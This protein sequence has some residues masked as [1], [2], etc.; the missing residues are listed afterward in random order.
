MC[1][2]S[3]EKFKPVRRDIQLTVALTAKTLKKCLRYET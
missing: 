3:W 1:E 2:N